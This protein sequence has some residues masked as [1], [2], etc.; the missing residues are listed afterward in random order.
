MRIEMTWPRTAGA[1]RRL[2]LT[3]P[4]EPIAALI[5]PLLQN[6][7][8]LFSRHALRRTLYYAEPVLGTATNGPGGQFALQAALTLAQRSLDPA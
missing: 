6:A 2:T 1:D 8:H 7:P 4:T 3:V 5:S